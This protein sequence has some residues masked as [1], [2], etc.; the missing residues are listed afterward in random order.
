MKTFVMDANALIAY[1]S[2]EA[3][4]DVVESFLM[5]TENICFAHAV[6]LCEVYYEY[7]RSGGPDKAAKV[8]ADL[9]GT[10]LITREDMDQELWQQA[11]DY[12]AE[13]RRISLADCF[14]AS[15]ADRLNAEVVTSD[16][17]EF[18]ALVNDSICRVKF[19]R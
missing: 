7:A 9:I 8:I 15:L 17:H 6:N 16:H 14:C 19:I 2:G 13:Y 3:G 1:L 12:K 10:G 5:D 18:D 4:G 11:G